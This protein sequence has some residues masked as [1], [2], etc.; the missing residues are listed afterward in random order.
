MIEG[1]YIYLSELGFL[2]VKGVSHPPGAVIAFPRLRPAASL[3]EVYA[4]I[5]ERVRGLLTFDDHSGQVLPQIPVEIVERHLSSLEGFRGMKPVDRLSHLAYEFGKAVSELGGVPPDSVG[6]SGSILLKAHGRDS[7]I[8]IVIVEP[9]GFKALDALRKLRARGVTSPVTHEYIHDLAAKRRDSKL[10][11]ETWVM[12]E[13]RKSTY[14]VFR[15]VVYSAKIVRRPEDFWEPWGSARW[16]E[17]GYAAVR[18]VVEDDMLGCYTPMKL[19]IRVEEVLEG[20]EEAWRCTE[21]ASYRS[22]FA[23]QVL[24]GEPFA[25]AGRLELDLTSR[26]YRLFV[27]NRPDDYIV[28]ETVI[29]KRRQ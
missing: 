24:A 10:G 28:S 17:L 12:H 15:G 4:F 6:V 16:R 19:R 27:G 21:I 9:R 18:G 11:L 7:D 29:H 1:D 8:D 13:G 2:A 25:A 26:R 3:D 5:E 23:E 22:R 20:G 14:G